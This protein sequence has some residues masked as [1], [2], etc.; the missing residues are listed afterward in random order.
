MPGNLGEV[1]AARVSVAGDVHALAH[2]VQ[3][4]HVD[5]APLRGVR[6]VADLPGPKRPCAPYCNGNR[7]AMRGPVS[8]MMNW[9][10]PGMKAL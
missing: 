1:D 3:A 10:K 5:E 6:F 8:A 9:E 2:A 4:G 7:P